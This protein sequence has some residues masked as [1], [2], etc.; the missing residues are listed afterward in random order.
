MQICVGIDSDCI[1]LSALLGELNQFINLA[2]ILLSQILTNW[3]E[4][5]NY[6]SL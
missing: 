4:F 3:C 2:I 1:H 5:N 6:Y